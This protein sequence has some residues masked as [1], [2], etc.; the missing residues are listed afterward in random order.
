MR[1]IYLGA[2]FL[3]EFVIRLGFYQRNSS[4]WGENRAILRVFFSVFLAFLWAFLC[5]CWI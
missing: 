2:S 1:L 4:F 5:L 3:W